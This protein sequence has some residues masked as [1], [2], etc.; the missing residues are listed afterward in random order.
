M[1]IEFMKHHL[2]GLHPTP[3]HRNDHDVIAL[4]SAPGTPF[5][6]SSIIIIIHPLCFKISILA[7]TRPSNRKIGA[8]KHHFRAAKR[9]R[10]TMVVVAWHC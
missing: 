10:R 7:C 9:K 3:I 2:P 6:G 5:F 8:F 1:G 4:M